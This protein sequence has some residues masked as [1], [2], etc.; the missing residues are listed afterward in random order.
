MIQRRIELKKLDFELKK[1]EFEKA[2][3]LRN[4]E[5]ENFWK[6]GWF[7]GALLLAIASGYFKLSNDTPDYCIF[8][9]FLG[10][11]VSLSQSLMNRGSK[12]WQERWENKTKNKESVLGIDLTKTRRFNGNEKY[13]L[14]ITTLAKD[15][16][17][18]TV[19]RRFSVSKLT[20]LVWDIITMLWIFLWI[21]DCHF[22]FAARFRTDAL[23]VHGMILSYIFLFFCLKRKSTDLGAKKW[24]H[25]FKQFGGG[26]VYDAFTKRPNSNAHSENSD[27]RYFEHSELYVDN[28]ENEIR[29]I[30]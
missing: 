26:K 28:N 11:L 7:F 18:L 2:L 9:A 25:F 13:L 1:L 22:S 30:Q 21:R 27:H 17:Y 10:L 3:E 19:A 16:N 29:N 14:D 4:F 20:F 6:R 5:I 15:E 24:Y 12:Y 8:L 23:L